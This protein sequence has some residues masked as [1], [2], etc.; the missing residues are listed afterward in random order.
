MQSFSCI[1]EGKD[2]YICLYS[3]FCSSCSYPDLSA[4]QPVSDKFTDVKRLCSWMFQRRD[5]VLGAFCPRACSR[6]SWGMTSERT[7]TGSS[8]H[9]CPTYRRSSLSVIGKIIGDQFSLILTNHLVYL[10]NDTQSRNGW[11]DMK[12]RDC[13]GLQQFPVKDLGTDVEKVFH[14]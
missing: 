10:G 1:Y 6:S 5:P 14:H 2:V 9:K 8:S 11:H 7:H 13:Y 3:H 12:S 4:F